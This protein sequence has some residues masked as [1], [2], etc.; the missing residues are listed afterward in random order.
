MSQRRTAAARGSRSLQEQVL[1]LALA[2]GEGL[3]RVVSGIRTHARLLCFVPAL[4]DNSG[5]GLKLVCRQGYRG[6]CADPELQEQ[7]VAL[8]EHRERRFHA[9]VPI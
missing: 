3:L 6:Y 1:V 5:G 4:T 8:V 9:L 7:R 2:N